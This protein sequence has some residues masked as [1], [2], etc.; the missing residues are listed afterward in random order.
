[1][2]DPSRRLS[3]LPLFVGL[4]AGAWAGLAL[5]E[6]GG[7]LAV[8]GLSMGVGLLLAHAAQTR[9]RL[10][11][12]AERLDA[13]E[14]GATP[15]AP[16]VEGSAGGA[17][18][19]ESP[20]RAPRP[21]RPAPRRADRRARPAAWRRA[22]P[23]EVEAG[24]QR[25]WA[26]ATG[27][28]PIVRVA[29][30]VL[31]VGFG[32]G[33]R[34]AAQLGLFP[35]EAR[36]AAAG[37]AGAGLIGLG[38]RLRATSAAFALAVQGGGV[39]LLYLTVYAAYA[40]V[41]LFGAPVALALMAAV[42]LVGGALAVVQD[43]P[44]LAFLGALGGFAA[45]VVAST[46]SGDHVLLFSYDLALG[47]GLGALVWRRGW[48]SLA[49]LGVVGTFGV[50]GWWGGLAYRPELY[51]TTQPFLVAFFALYFALAL[52]LAWLDLRASEA[53]AERDLAV[54][55][56]LLFGLPA[57]TFVLQQGL[58]EGLRFGSA[59]S[60]GALAAVYL[61]AWWAVRRRLAP[62][63]LSD[64]LL[65]VGLA[66][67]I[68][69]TPLAFNRVVTGTL[70]SLQAA[71]LVWTGARQHALWMRLAGI[72]LGVGAAT[73]L[74]LG[75]VL[76]AGRAFTP[77]TLTGWIVAV[78]LALSAFV[79]DRMPGAR[80]W[81]QAAGRLLL[82][83]AVVWWGLTAAT[84]ADTLAPAGAA[85]AAVLGALG[86][87][88]ALFAGVGRRLAWP[89]LRLAAL[90][91]G[92]VA[93]AGALV[94]LQVRAFGPGSDAGPFDL[95]G[96]LG[97][98]LLVAGAVVA[99]RGADGSRLHDAAFALAAWAVVCVAAL[100]LSTWPPPAW[101]DGWRVLTVGAP[102]ALALAARRGPA[103]RRG[104]DAISSPPGR[105]LAGGGLAAAAAGAAFLFSFR[106]GSAAPA[107]SLPLLSP[108]DLTVAALLA[109]LTAWLARHR[110]P[111]RP[112]AWGLG[113]LALVAIGGV[114]ARA[115]HHLAGVPFRPDALFDAAAFQAPLAVAWAGLA[116]GLTVAASRRGSRAL[117][118]AGA[119]VLALVVVKLFAV[120]LSRADALVRVG[121]FLLVGAVMLWIGYRSPLPPRARGGAAADDEGR[122]TGA[123]RGL[124]GAPR[125]GAPRPDL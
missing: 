45:P 13:V 28:N 123:P 3:V 23:P 43:A 108:A 32:V 94:E 63:L 77:E 74:L 98:P 27:G 6:L 2:P 46:G 33:L 73:V 36:L 125:A 41:G 81:E 51:A 121:A 113:A 59:W 122:P 26:F 93:A 102:V 60:A 101:G 103:L 61:G 71:A 18:A 56:T 25:A 55:G 12:V 99:L 70:W 37:L 38:W 64:A 88:A 68:L 90:V 104:L 14:R 89:D 96:W 115:A 52:R 69:A 20:G 53:P 57:A 106:P 44:G 17:R 124:P 58:V 97:W 31:F 24:L 4:G 100:E 78:S 48:R 65:A 5:A 42:A 66:F 83:G 112:V 29:L 80:A 92:P 8:V 50:G 105:R 91:A 9:R 1:M 95:G 10:R 107:P 54:D 16:G 87:S 19:A 72:A 30:V 22:L 62:R 11:D 86:V 109:T 15:L 76:D 110:A 120:D 35:V 49:V 119:I 84:H 85:R 47:L 34:Y 114:V 40:L 79:L 116:L 82:A 39:A 67:A 118:T 7:D 21:L 111:T 75:G 117:W